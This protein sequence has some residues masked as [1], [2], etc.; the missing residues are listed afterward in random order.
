MKKVLLLLSGLI[1]TLIFSQNANAQGGRAGLGIRL[2]PDGAGF[3]GKF[4][5]D[6]NLAFEAQLNAGG[7][8]GG[9]GQSVNAVGLLQYHIPLPD[10]SWRIFFGGGAHIGAW[11]RDKRD[12]EG[13]RGDKDNEFIFGIDG[14]GGL[15][16][17]FKKIPLGLSADF[18]PAINLVSDVDFFPHNM[19][20]VSARLYLR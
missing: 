1:L 13:R 3:T 16:Y 2:S 17:V 8:F 6:R 4:F 12:R 9:E 11:D 15:E 18:K 14:V 5:V 7:V 20:G 19:F 10:P